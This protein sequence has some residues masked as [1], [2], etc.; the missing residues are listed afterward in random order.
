MP[1][2]LSNDLRERV[3]AAKF[4]NAIA[5][6]GGVAAI[7][8]AMFEALK[9]SKKAEFALD[10]PYAETF[11]TLTVPRYIAEGLIWLQERLKK[12]QI[13][14]LPPAEEAAT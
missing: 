1:H 7:G 3:V 5:A 4:R 12:K 6:G 2:P 8:A 14:V 13:E 9:T 11:E 10:I